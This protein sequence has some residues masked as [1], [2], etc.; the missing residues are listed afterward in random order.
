MPLDLQAKLLR[1]LQER[2]ITRL[3]SNEPVPLDVRFI[4]TSK[5]DLAQAGGRRAGS[6]RICSTG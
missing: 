2:V 6:A 1:V 3:G 4:A 5:A